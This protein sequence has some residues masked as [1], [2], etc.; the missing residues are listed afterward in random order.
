MVLVIL[1]LGTLGFVF[2]QN[3]IQSKDNTPETN[4]T[5]TT[6]K[7]E[8][9]AKVKTAV[10]TVAPGTV[11]NDF[12]LSFMSYMKADSVSDASY[13]SQ[14]NALTDAYK[15]R[16]I[17]PNG[18][19]YASPIILAQ[20]LPSYFTIENVAIDDDGSRVTVSLG[21]TSSGATSGVY[22]LIYDLVV[23]NNEW[24]IDGVIKG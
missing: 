24:K 17:N 18:P 16:I 5:K 20:A 3:F 23:V 4:A 11:V 15:D 9:T 12:L 21:F 10:P 1:L 22:T 7:T 13:A 19:V 8:T 2:Y 6:T 14:S